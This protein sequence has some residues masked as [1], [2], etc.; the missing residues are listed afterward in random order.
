[1]RNPLPEAN[2][3]GQ[4]VAALDLTG[5]FI[6]RSGHSKGDRLLYD[7]LAC[8]LLSFF[9]FF[10]CTTSWADPYQDSRVSRPS[11]LFSLN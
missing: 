10:F 4:F 8:P 5:G 3:R 6:A 1:M 2:N 7:K 9:I 11:T